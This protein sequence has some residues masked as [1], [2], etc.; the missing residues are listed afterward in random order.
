MLRGATLHGKLRIVTFLDAILKIAAD[1][2]LA[3]CSHE[4]E[5]SGRHPSICVYEEGVFIGKVRWPHS[6]HPALDPGSALAQRLVV[7]AE[8]VPNE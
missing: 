5:R 1:P 8:I 4:D 6:G 3:F 7:D 2:A